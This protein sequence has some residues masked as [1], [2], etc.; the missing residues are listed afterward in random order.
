MHF[1]K[2]KEQNHIYFLCLLIWAKQLQIYI[3]IM[4]IDVID[5]SN[6]IAEDMNS[7]DEEGDFLLLRAFNIS[8]THLCM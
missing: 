8:I 6:I 5:E 1:R 7:D 3:F 2:L 4:Y